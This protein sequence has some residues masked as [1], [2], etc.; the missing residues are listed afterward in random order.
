M[1]LDRLTVGHIH[2]VKRNDVEEADYYCIYIRCDVK[3]LNT[4]Y[5][6]M[7]YQKNNNTDK[8]NYFSCKN[9][10]WIINITYYEA[11]KIYH[12]STTIRLNFI[13]TDLLIAFYLSSISI[14]N[15]ATNVAYD[16]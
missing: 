10:Q 8:H 9:R 12:L 6:F 11:D 5:K 13:N 16:F 1:L 2:F 7:V 14:S 3:P 15:V 4:W